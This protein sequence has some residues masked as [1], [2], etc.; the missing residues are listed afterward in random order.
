MAGGVL[1]EPLGTGVARGLERLRVG[2]GFC[3]DIEAGQIHTQTGRLES[4]FRKGVMAL[5]EHPSVLDEEQHHRLKHGSKPISHGRWQAWR[6]WVNRRRPGYRL[7]YWRDDDEFCF[8][9]VRIHDDYTIDA[10]P[11]K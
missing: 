5:A 1:S 4:V 3:A 2:E 8:M 6:L 7:H 9:N 10:P 11:G